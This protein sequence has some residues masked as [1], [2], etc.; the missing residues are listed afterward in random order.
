MRSA[1]LTVFALLALPALASAA[2]APVRGQWSKSCDTLQHCAAEQMAYAEP[3]DKPVLRVRFT[4]EPEGRGKIVVLAPLGISLR[5][6]LDLVVDSAAPIKLP[7][8]RC[9]QQ[10]CE[11]SAVLDQAA[12]EKF[13]KGTTLTVR[14]APTDA[15]TATVPLKLEGLAA[16]LSSLPR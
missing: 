4:N 7:F 10:G 13:V 12:L 8:E 16:A 14:Y 5:A 11:V 9:D 2:S 3:G 1:V 15:L 6:G